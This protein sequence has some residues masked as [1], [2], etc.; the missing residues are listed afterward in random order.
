MGPRPDEPNIFKNSEPTKKPKQQY[1][2]KQ[3]YL[4]K[5][6]KYKMKYLRLKGVNKNFADKEM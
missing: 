5:Y 3:D 6:Q 2:K 4:E 1:E